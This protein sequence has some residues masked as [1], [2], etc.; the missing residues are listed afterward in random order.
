MIKELY[1]K[2]LNK[3]SEMLIILIY[4]YD[5]QFQES[6]V[7]FSNFYL[8]YY[9]IWVLISNNSFMCVDIN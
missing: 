2:Q 4:W 5:I 7:V 8:Y 1:Y 9:V 3:L 6:D